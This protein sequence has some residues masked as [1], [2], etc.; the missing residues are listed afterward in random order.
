MI[1][2]INLGSGEHRVDVF[3]E[4]KLQCT[5]AGA[6][7]FWT[8]VY[9]QDLDPSTALDTKNSYIVLLKWG[10]IG[11][12]GQDQ[13][14]RFRTIPLAEAYLRG[15]LKDKMNKNYVVMTGGGTVGVITQAAAVPYVETEWDLL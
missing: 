7:K 6:N 2:K 11:T 4:H 1:Q 13:I 9:G 15:R 5:E 8:A 12:A 10:K 14:K 3:E